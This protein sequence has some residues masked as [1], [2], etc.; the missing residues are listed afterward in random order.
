MTRE[1]KNNY[2]LFNTYLGCSYIFKTNGFFIRCFKNVKETFISIDNTFIVTKFGSNNYYCFTVAD[3]FPPTYLDF[4]F[5]CYN[6][7]LCAN[8]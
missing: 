7:S 8:M 6:N 3:T 4:R 2:K 5:I 1:L